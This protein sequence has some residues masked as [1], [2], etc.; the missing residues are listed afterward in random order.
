MPAASGHPAFFAAHAGIENQKTFLDSRLRGSDRL[1]MK[2][3]HAL[4]K[5]YGIV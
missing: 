5:N 2:K 1:R 4:L 3:N